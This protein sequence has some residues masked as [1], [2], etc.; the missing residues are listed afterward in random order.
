MLYIVYKHHLPVGRHRVDQQRDQRGGDG[1]DDRVEQVAREVELR[2]RIG[3]ILPRQPELAYA[4]A[5]IDRNLELLRRTRRVHHL[6]D[7]ADAI[8]HHY[9]L[10]IHAAW[11]TRGEAVAGSDA[12]AVR[13]FG[14]NE[15]ESVALTGTTATLLP[16]ARAALML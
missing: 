6:R 1:D 11:S 16:Q 7:D 10:A 12:A 5:P 3:V 13:W 4:L 2:E 8:E 15:L 9:V 14:E